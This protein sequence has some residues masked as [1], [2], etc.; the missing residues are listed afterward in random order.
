[1]IL[2]VQQ[3]R[4]PKFVFV[5]CSR[6]LLLDDYRGL[7]YPIGDCHNPLWEILFTN[8][9]GPCWL[10]FLK[11]WD[12]NRNKKETRLS[13][14]ST[15]SILPANCLAYLS[16]TWSFL[17]FLPETASGGGKHMESYGNIKVCDMFEAVIPWDRWCTR[18]SV[19]RGPSS[20][21]NPFSELLPK[22]HFSTGIAEF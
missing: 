9:Q 2:K 17:H 5:Q 16:F 20:H 10:T 22:L 1:M 15:A 8:T 13:A 12:W 4:W 11:S 3:G 19:S 14:T 7:Y 18:C 6:P 21:G